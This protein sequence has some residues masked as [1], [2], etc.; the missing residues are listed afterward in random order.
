TMLAVPMLKENE[1]IGSF[2]FGRTEIRPFTDKQIEIVQSFAAQAVV[3]VENARLLH[4][5]RETLQQQT[6]TAK[7]LQIIAS[8]PGDL[9]PVFETVL[10][11][12]SRLCD[13]EFGN[14]YRWH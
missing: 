9:K 14:I 6:A 8:S 7:V 10:E 1:L 5:L 2:S 4:E 13:A 12:A 3:A 11:N